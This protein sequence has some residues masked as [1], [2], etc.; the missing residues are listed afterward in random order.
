MLNRHIFH[1]LL[2]RMDKVMDRRTE[3]REDGSETM[4]D[5][6]EQTVHQGRE[7]RGDK[8]A[9]PIVHPREPTQGS[10]GP[11]SPSAAGQEAQQAQ[12]ARLTHE[13]LPERTNLADPN[14]M[15][16]LNVGDTRIQLT[17][18][19]LSAMLK[20]STISEL[21]LGDDNINTDPNSLLKVKSHGNALQLTPLHVAIL[22]RSKID[23]QHLARRGAD[24]ESLLDLDVGGLYAKLSPLQLAT[25]VRSW[26]IAQTLLGNHADAH[27]RHTLGIRRD[28]Q[29]EVTPLHVLLFSEQG[30]VPGLASMRSKVSATIELRMETDISALDAAAGMN[31]AS[32]IALFSDYEF[33]VAAASSP[34]TG[35]LRILALMIASASGIDMLGQAGLLYLREVDDKTAVTVGVQMDAYFSSTVTMSLTFEALATILHVACALGNTSMT[36]ALIAK[37]ASVESR[38]DMNAGDT[39][40]AYLTPLHLAVLGRHSRTAYCLLQHDASLSASAEFHVERTVRGDVLA[41]HLAEWLG[42]NAVSR[43]VEKAAGTVRIKVKGDLAAIHLVALTGDQET[44]LTLLNHDTTVD[45]PCS[46]HLEAKT[47]SKHELDLHVNLQ[48]QL[49]PLHLAVAVG[50]AHLIPLLVQSGDNVEGPIKVSGITTVERGGA[51]VKRTVDATGTALHLAAALGNMQTIHALLDNGANVHAKSDNGRTA[52]EWAKTRGHE[53][54]ARVLREHEQRDGAN[55]DGKQR[56]LLLK[57]RW[58]DV[59]SRGT[60]HTSG[61]V[62]GQQSFVH[63]DREEESSQQDTFRPNGVAGMIARWV[64]QRA[65]DRRDK[66][67]KDR[68]S[69]ATDDEQDVD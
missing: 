11:P 56:R 13:T 68:L 58:H 69:S 62:E 27:A 23:M 67:N 65:K 61:T 15:L 29:T 64:T 4:T 40:Q 24:L 25:I 20:A 41:P 10:D 35:W 48:S 57:Q 26:D 39:M 49:T 43:L 7:S 22:R 14:A 21:L 51:R 3:A 30:D 63:L 66:A 36:R 38:C 28:F 55:D 52:Y 60:L 37:G 8:G 44:M 50:R 54:A 2:E 34:K 1:P 45:S 32:M 12:E 16:L 59:F 18:L 17:A 42:N 33:H 9:A 6:L 47:A 19:H 53:D 31:Q 5:G 46:A